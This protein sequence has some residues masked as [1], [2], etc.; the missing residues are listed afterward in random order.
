MKF[1]LTVIGL[2]F[3]TIFAIITAMMGYS[4]IASGYVGVKTRFG[5][6]VNTPMDPGLHFIVPYIE[7][8]VQLDTR[9]KSYPMDAQASSKDLQ[10]I[11]TKIS[12][13]H[14]LNANV[15]PKAYQSVGDLKQLDETI[16]SPSIQE[17]SKA[18][19]A[20]YTAE[21]LITKRDTVK[22][23]IVMA[24]QQFIDGTL[25]DKGID[26][27]IHVSNVAINDFDFSNEFNASIE[28]KVKAQQEA[29]KAETEKVMRIT[30]AE[31]NQA[32]KQL[33]ADAEAYQVEKVSMQRAA[34]IER[35]AKALADNPRLI[36][37]RA[38]EKWDGKL[39]TF[40]GGNSP[41]PFI[42]VDSVKK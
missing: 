30:N 37:L 40:S 9:L 21:E 19:I 26:G 8:V 32:E 41:V 29:L 23:Q 38:I 1:Q 13:Q 14:S 33:S 7:H 11:N 35:E 20:H 10:V 28:A 15:A 12:V 17:S 31:A 42:N 4:P 27:A 22:S 34:A 16:V 36:E 5:A 18:V 2:G 25:K 39:P 3:L 24:I 6:V